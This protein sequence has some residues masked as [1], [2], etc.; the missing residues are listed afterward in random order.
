[1]M[2]QGGAG[3]DDAKVS[4]T[5]TLKQNAAA[6]PGR[7]ANLWWCMRGLLQQQREG[8]AHPHWVGGKSSRRPQRK[9]GMLDSGMKT[10]TMLCA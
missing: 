10:V 3:V 8:G 7:E 9:H 4:E 1:M 6:R 2:C 5:V